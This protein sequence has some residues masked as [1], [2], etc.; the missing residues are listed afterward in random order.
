MSA[1]EATDATPNAGWTASDDRT[2]RRDLRQLAWPIAV[3]MVSYS[4]MSLADTLFVG[5]L[6]PA[7]IAGVGLGG[8]AAFTIVCFI[9]G[10]LQGSKVLVSQAVGAGRD[11]LAARHA[12]AAMVV[13]VALGFVALVVG[14]AIAQLLPLLTASAESGVAAR[15][16]LAIRMIGSP[17][18]MLYVASREVRYGLGDS[19]SPMVASVTGN[20][21]NIGLDALFIFGLDLGVAG[22]AWA[23]IVGQLVELLVL[24]ALSR[25]RVLARPQASDLRALFAIGIPTGL[26]LLLEVGSFALLTAL[27]AAFAEREMAAHQIAIQVLHF[28]FLPTIAVGEASSVLVGRAVGAD[29]DDAVPRIARAALRVSGA[30][31]ALCTLVLLTL[32]EPLARAFTDDEALIATTRTLLLIAAAFQIVDALNVVGRS[33]LRG[34]GDVRWAAVVGVVA[35][36]LCTPPLTLLLGYGLGLGAVG[37]WIGLCAEIA[38]GAALIWHRVLRGRWRVIAAEMR[39]RD[40]AAG[41]AVDRVALAAA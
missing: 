25:R 20:L 27:I 26:Q 21:T 1:P 3:S 29:R 37:G 12:G 11:H 38:I 19:R 8:V 16:Y 34:A 7:S 35:A 5:R 32:S 14:V 13:A 39:R 17:I 23:T 4:L 2:I 6:G 41:E 28:S 36:W 18:V 30:Y 10:L 40:A 31:A 24:V 9:I 22:A 33:V 15:D